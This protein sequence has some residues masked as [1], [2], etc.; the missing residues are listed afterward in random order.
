MA[1]WARSP[2]RKTTAA[3]LSGIFRLE[4][5]EMLSLTN[6]LLP[7]I[8]KKAAHKIYAVPAGQEKAD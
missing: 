1:A 7:A 6:L 2:N 3:P 4:L 8:G 5:R